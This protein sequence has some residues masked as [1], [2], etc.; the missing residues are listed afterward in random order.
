M[1]SFILK[2]ISPK[3]APSLAYIIEF[4]SVLADF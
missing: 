1:L 4:T 2:D 3:K